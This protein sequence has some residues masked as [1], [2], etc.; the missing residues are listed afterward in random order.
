MQI[1]ADRLATPTGRLLVLLPP[2]QTTPQDYLD[3]GFVAEVR[4]RGLAADILIPALD[5]GHVMAGTVVDMLDAHVLAPARAAGYR[6]IWLA[7]IS[8]GAFNALLCA[9]ARET[10]LAGLCLMAPYPG[11]G[12]ILA[13]IR[14]AGGPQAWATTP[15]AQGGDERV[16]WRW[17]A[18]RQ[19]RDSVPVWFGCGSEDR[20]IRNQLLLAQ[21]LPAADTH[22]QAGG[23]DWPTWQKLWRHWLDHGPLART[24]A[25]DLTDAS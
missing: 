23:H 25:P 10:E 17:L 5:H 4:Q 14:A 19:H 20:F 7:G 21:L 6:E 22:L 3:Q 13:E 12:D 15:A 2:A 8:L 9:A 1:L 11:T 16:F 24:A 18:Q